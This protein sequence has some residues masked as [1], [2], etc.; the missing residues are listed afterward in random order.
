M[1][2]Y[3]AASTAFQ[4]S[5]ILGLG[6]RD[7]RRAI[8]TVGREGKQLHSDLPSKSRWA[9]PRLCAHITYLA[10]AQ[11]DGHIHALIQ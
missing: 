7:I 2:K 11:D 5:A 9:I 10:A 6:E 1:S 4:I 3:Y 8:A